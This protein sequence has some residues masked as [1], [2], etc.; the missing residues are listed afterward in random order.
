MF[1]GI[2]EMSATEP[3]AMKLE[4]YL[5]KSGDKTEKFWTEENRA[6]SLKHEFLP[7]RHFSSTYL[8]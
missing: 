6:C 4:G 5:D 7:A 1:S 3:S 8:F 2:F